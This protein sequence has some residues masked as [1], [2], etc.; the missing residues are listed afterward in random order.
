LLAPGGDQRALAPGSARS[1]DKA[2][3]PP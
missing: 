3:I 1:Q 2:R